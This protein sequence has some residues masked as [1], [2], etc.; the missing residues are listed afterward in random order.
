MSFSKLKPAGCR[1]KHH[2][3]STKNCRTTKSKSCTRKSRSHS[4]SGH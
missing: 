4:R 1:R 2:K 3:K